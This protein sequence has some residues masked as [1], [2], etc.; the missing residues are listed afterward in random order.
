LKHQRRRTIRKKTP[1]EILD[2][3]MIHNLFNLWKIMLV[4]LVHLQTAALSPMRTLELCKL[5]KAEAQL[6][7]IHYPS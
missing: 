7:R 2:I 6:T 5:H 4:D 3:P 1:K